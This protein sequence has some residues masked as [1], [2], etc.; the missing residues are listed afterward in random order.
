M[1]AG[2]GYCRAR[3]AAGILVILL[4]VF[5]RSRHIFCAQA[6]FTIRAEGVCTSLRARQATEKQSEPLKLL[7]RQ[8]KNTVGRRKT[9]EGVRE[10]NAH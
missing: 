10:G 3:K 2:G 8:N 4:L 5:F 9:E 6:A 1:R 7:K